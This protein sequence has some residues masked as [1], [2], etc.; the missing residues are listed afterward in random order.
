MWLSSSAH[1]KRVYIICTIDETIWAERHSV[2]H[3]T[4]LYTTE[5]AAPT[6]MQKENSNQINKIKRIKVLP[7]W[8]QQP[9][10]PRCLQTL[11][12]WQ[13]AWQTVQGFPAVHRSGTP[14]NQQGSY[15]L[16][17]HK[18]HLLPCHLWAVLLT[19]PKQALYRSTLAF[20][21]RPSTSTAPAVQ[22]SLCHVHSLVVVFIP[23]HIYAANLRLPQRVTRLISWRYAGETHPSSLCQNVKVWSQHVKYLYLWQQKKYWRHIKPFQL[24]RLHVGSPLFSFLCFP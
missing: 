18:C 4:V 20:W 5:M 22:V 16:I 11:P 2:R 7:A 17:T 19:V 23:C 24:S 14:E 13:T 15:S 1:L 21:Q 10:S 6:A 3:R 8:Q 12:V 9:G